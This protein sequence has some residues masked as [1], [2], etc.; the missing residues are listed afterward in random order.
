MT[1]VD[2]RTTWRIRH[3]GSP[4]SVD[5]LTL[6][7]VVEGLQ[8]GL[9]E[10]TDEVMGPN[11][12]D[13]IAIENHPQLE[14]VALDLEPPPRRTYDDETRLDMNA[15]IDVCLVLLI[16]FMIITSYSVLQKRLE[17]PQITNKDIKGMKVIKARDIQEQM[18][19]V[20]VKMEGDKPVIRVED[21]VVGLDELEAAFH[22]ATAGTTKT[23][24]LL[25]ED[26]DVPYGT[27]IAIRDAASAAH[28]EHISL[29]AP[30]K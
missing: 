20:K 26:D 25:E 8:N 2:A 15:L 30:Q 23:Q 19:W 7:S 29:V 24:L 4:R 3:E 10:P 21:K 22:R 5:D 11:D 16:F 1:T 6:D 12:A 27:I 9:W 28:L 14:E 17:Q 18:L 13:W